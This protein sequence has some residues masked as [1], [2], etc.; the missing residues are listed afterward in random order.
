[1]ILC[2]DWTRKS[3][4]L[5]KSHE[6]TNFTSKAELS[7]QLSDWDAILH[8]AYQYVFLPWLNIPSQSEFGKD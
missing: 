8:E 4:L 1:M 6:L 2:E 5:I 7:I 3:G